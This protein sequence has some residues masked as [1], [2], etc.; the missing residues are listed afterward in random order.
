MADPLG[1]ERGP[2][3]GEEVIVPITSARR[4]RPVAAR[5]VHD[6]IKFGEAWRVGPASP[7]RLSCVQTLPGAARHPPP[8]GKRLPLAPA[9]WGSG[10]GGLPPPATPSSRTAR[11]RSDQVW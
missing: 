10:G 6:Q 1:R 5:H 7:G 4:L 3:D 11:S 2:E 8:A 9:R